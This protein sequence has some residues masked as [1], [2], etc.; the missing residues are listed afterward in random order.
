MA[1]LMTLDDS[2]N[3]SDKF[4]SRTEGLVHQAQQRSDPMSEWMWQLIEDEGVMRVPTSGSHDEK[5]LATDYGD[6]MEDG[7]KVSRSP[8]VSW[9]RIVFIFMLYIGGLGELER[10]IQWVSFRLRFRFV[11]VVRAMRAG[12]AK[13]RGRVASHVVIAGPPG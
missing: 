13:L 9:W 7:H 10:F 4:N 2:L 8:V 6:V 5:R 12:E 1:G 11:R 3:R